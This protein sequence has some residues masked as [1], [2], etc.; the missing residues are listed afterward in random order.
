M[1]KVAI[2]QPYWFPYIG[3]FQLMNAVDEFIVYDNIQYTKKGWINRNRILFAGRPEQISLPVEAASHDCDVRDRRLAGNWPEART[4]LLNRI[5]NYYRGASQFSIVFPLIEACLNCRERGVFH[6]IYFS[7][8]Q[9]REYLHIKS[10]LVVSSS[11][12]I[13]PHMQGEDRVIAL[14]SGRNATTYINPIGGVDLYSKKRFSDSGINLL[15]LK[16]LSPPY[17]Q[18]DSPF[19]PF[20]SIIDV[21][22]FNERGYISESILP[23]FTVV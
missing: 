8:V 6:F 19:I 4:K 20:L 3:Y 10:K 13:P 18:F 15:F 2:M 17:R 12:E 14:C 9:V 23:Q 11:V 22:M 16:S 21:M 5:Q 1:L 7:L